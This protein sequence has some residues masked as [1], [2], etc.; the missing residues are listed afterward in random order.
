MRTKAFSYFMP[1]SERFIHRY[2]IDV[3]QIASYR[4]AHRDTSDVQHMID[5]FEAAGFFYGDQ[6][7]RFFD[8]TNN[9]MIARSRSADAARI[10]ISEVIAHRAENDA[11]LN[12]AHRSYQTIEVVVR[13]AHDVKGDPLRGFVPNAGK[14]FKFID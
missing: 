10:D 13:R 5:T 3:F 8:D 7:V 1:V 12:I 4:H 11:L 14:A 9:G 2:F 6:A